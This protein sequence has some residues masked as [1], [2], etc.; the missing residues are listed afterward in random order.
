M[1]RDLSGTVEGDAVRLVSSYTERHGDSL[2]FT[3]SGKLS[4]DSL[5]GTL[6]MGEYLTAKWTARRHQYGQA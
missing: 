6:D 3:F 5:S 1:S 2:Q 4:G